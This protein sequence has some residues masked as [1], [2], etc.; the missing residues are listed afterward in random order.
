MITYSVPFVS[1]YPVPGQEPMYNDILNATVWFMGIATI[2]VNVADICW[3]NCST[4][5]NNNG[6]HEFFI[7]L[8]LG[9]IFSLSIVLYYFRRTK[10]SDEADFLQTDRKKRIYFSLVTAISVITLEMFDIVTD[11]LAIFHIWDNNHYD[12][13]LTRLYVVFSVVGCFMVSFQLTHLGRRVGGLITELR[14]GVEVRTLPQNTQYSMIEHER[15]I[16]LDIGKVKKTVNEQ[17]VKW[18]HVSI[19][20]LCETVPL[21]ILN[22]CLIYTSDDSEHIPVQLFIS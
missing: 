9:V 1:H 7:L 12:Q 16:S 4:D 6:W 15:S 5:E 20:M 11:V 3:E 19:G 10:Q 2:D 14:E 13:N 17:L 22:F 21:F 18:K 8:F